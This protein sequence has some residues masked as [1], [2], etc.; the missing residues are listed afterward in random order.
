MVWGFLEVNTGVVCAA[1]PAIKPLF[2]RFLPQL[3]SSRS[4]RSAAVGRSSEVHQ[5]YSTSIERNRKR[6]VG[7]SATAGPELA[8]ED[9]TMFVTRQGTRSGTQDDQATLPEDEETL[10]SGQKAMS[11]GGARS[12]DRQGDEISLDSWEECLDSQQERTL[13]TVSSARGASRPG[14][15][16]T[17]PRASLGGDGIVVTKE[18]RV[19]G[20]L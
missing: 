7:N 18:T 16:S 17:G 13:T 8:D 19:R 6:R 11:K 12:L 9:T 14:E 10:W 20:G 4:H 15:D 2:S 1:L 3:L 5:P